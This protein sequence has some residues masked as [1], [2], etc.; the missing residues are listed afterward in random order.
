MYVYTSIKFRRPCNN[1]NPEATFSKQVTELHLYLQ[2]KKEILSSDKGNM[3][4]LITVNI[5]Q[6]YLKQ[7]ILM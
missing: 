3:Y 6:Y 4:C 7:Y 5:K 2:K 1:L